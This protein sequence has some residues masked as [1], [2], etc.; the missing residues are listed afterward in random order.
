MQIN[1]CVEQNKTNFFHAIHFKLDYKK[2]NKIFIR[3]C[4]KITINID[5]DIYCEAEVGIRNKNKV[6]YKL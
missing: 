4:F 5:I 6:K 2:L 1:G 3:I